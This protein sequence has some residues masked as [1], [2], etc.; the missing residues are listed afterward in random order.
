MGMKN[1]RRKDFIR[2][3]PAGQG[4][5]TETLKQAAL[6]PETL[7]NRSAINRSRPMVEIRNIETARRA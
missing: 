6:P 4:D 1:G 5:K 3:L 7:K 2:F